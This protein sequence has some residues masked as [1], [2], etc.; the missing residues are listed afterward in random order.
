MKTYHLFISHSW[1]YHDQY[2]NLVNLL[3]QANNFRYHN[4][5]IPKKVPVLDSTDKQLSK[6]IHNKMQPCGIVIVLAGVYAEYSEWIDKEIKIAK[7]GFSKPKPILAL[8]P[9]TNEISAKVRDHADQ[10]VGWNTNS[11]VSAIRELAQ[12]TK[13]DRNFKQEQRK[14]NQ[15]SIG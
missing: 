12:W 14:S 5:S 9:C 1:T 7:S 8:R 13:S 10:I 3:K 4:H 11:I 2:S 6:V 15:L